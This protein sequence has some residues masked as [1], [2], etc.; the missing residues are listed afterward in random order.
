MSNTLG[1]CGRQI[2]FIYN[3]YNFKIVVKRKICICKSLRLNA[4]RSV[5][6]KHCTLT[7]RKRTGYL[8]VKVNMTG[9]V[10]QIKLVGLTVL[11]GIIE[12]YGVCLDCNTS[13]T[14]K[15]HIIKQLIRHI[16]LCNRVGKLQKSVCKGRFAVVNVSDNR[17]ISDVF[18][19]CHKLPLI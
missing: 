15:V 13:F 11:C 3:R 19:F 1:V 9:G 8:I 7:S 18:L 12:L 14:L 10:N 5:N 17:E 4:L 16:T 6:D 2:Y